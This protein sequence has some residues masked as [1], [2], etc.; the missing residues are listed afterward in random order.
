MTTVARLRTQLDAANDV[1]RSANGFTQTVAHSRVSWMS[2]TSFIRGGERETC[3]VCDS[4]ISAKTAT[5]ENIRGALERLGS[6]SRRFSKTGR[7][8]THT[9]NG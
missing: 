1:L 2:A 3:P 6:N 4:P 7:R 8:L 5:L 9:S